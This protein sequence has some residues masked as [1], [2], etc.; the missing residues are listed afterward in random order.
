[1]LYAYVSLGVLLTGITIISPNQNSNH[2]E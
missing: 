2:V 1:M